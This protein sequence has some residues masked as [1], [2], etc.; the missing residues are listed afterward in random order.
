MCYL[1]CIVFPPQAK[2]DTQNAKYHAAAAWYQAGIELLI[3]EFGEK[4]MD[5]ST[6][7]PT[8]NNILLRDVIET[9][10]PIFFEHQRDPE[11]NQM[12]AFPARERAAFM[13]HWAKLLGDATL[14]KQTILFEGQVAGN[15][16]SFEQHGM[17]EIGYWIGR[18][19]WGKGIATQA[20]AAFLAQVQVRPLYALVAKHNI[21]S[22]RVLEK[23]G[24]T[25]LSTEVAADG[26]EEVLL[27]LE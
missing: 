15:I 4:T 2:N 13:A 10:L 24:F 8:T 11:A 1:L 21:A 19:Y 5:K 16:G 23:C 3:P 17:R 7:S 22:R 14:I 20:L 26:V 18:E 12:A 27:K 25:I 6:P 9:D